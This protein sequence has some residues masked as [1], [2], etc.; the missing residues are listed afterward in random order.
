MQEPWLSRLMCV[1]FCCQNECLFTWQL[2]RRRHRSR[3]CMPSAY[4]VIYSIVRKSNLPPLF[5]GFDEGCMDGFSIWSLNMSNSASWFWATG[6]KGSMLCWVLPSA[7]LGGAPPLPDAC[8]GSLS[9][10]PGRKNKL[11]IE[12]QACSVGFVQ[13]NPWEQNSFEQSAFET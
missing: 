9:A 4:P 1:F 6:E 7:L 10:G 8:Q 11:K 2:L 3:P 12:H 13:Q 5:G